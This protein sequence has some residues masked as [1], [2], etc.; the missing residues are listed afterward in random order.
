MHVLSKKALRKFWSLHSDAERPL[1]RWFRIVSKAR[2]KSF[3]EVRAT[4]GTA[5]QVERFTVFNI[6]GNKYRLIAIIHYNRGKV[7]VR[8]VLTHK[9]YDLGKWQDN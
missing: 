5:D 3:A 7:F 8:H 1:R 4:F 9:E 2:W 6:A